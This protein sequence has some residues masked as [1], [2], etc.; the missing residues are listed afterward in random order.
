M[1]ASKKPTIAPE[2]NDGAPVTVIIVNWNAG[3]LLAECIAHLMG[4]TCQP[5]AVMVVDNASTDD[6]LDQLTAL[7]AWAPLTVLRMPTN[8]GF[9]AGNNY[10]IERCS[11]PFIAL[12]NPDAFAAPDWLAQLLHAAQTQPAAA[13][14]GSRQL[15]HENP[16]LLDGTGDCYHASGLAWREHHGQPQ[17]PAHLQ[18]REIFAPCAAAALYR[19]SAVQN[20]GGFDESYF[21]Y[22]ED[23]DL[24]FRLRLA[25]HTAQYVPG[26][27]V[28]HVGSATT[29]GQ[30]SDF[31]TFHGHRNMAW[32]FVKNMPGILFWLLLPLHL[33]AHLAACA[34]LAAR[35]QARTAA[36]ARWHALHGL[37]AAWR[38]RQAIQRKRTATVASIWRALDKQLWPRPRRSSVP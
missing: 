29:G 7:P 16:A 26:A 5:A 1:T 15:C 28:R 20:V 37:G 17:T 32:T 21:C 9:A 14:W 2:Q 27:V 3:P 31:A 25:G 38:Q 30:R 36:R 34:V 12:L 35:G 18:A 23:V 10:A 22:F 13:A 33:A 6:S 19:R 4:Q 8:L 11:T 24:G